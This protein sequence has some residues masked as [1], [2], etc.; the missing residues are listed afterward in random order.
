MEIVEQARPD[1]AERDLIARH[2]RRNNLARLP[3]VGARF[4]HAFYLKDAAGDVAGGLWVDML[5]DWVYIELLFVPETLRGQGIGADLIRRVE[6]RARDWQAVGI[7]V[8]TFGFQARSFY[9]KQGYDCFAVLEGRTPEAD[10][11]M[12]RKYLG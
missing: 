8:S 9:E 6:A 3:R 11:N 1:P 12:L 10:D 4:A 2:L 5:L 7:W